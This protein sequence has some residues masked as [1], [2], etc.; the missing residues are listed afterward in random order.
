MKKKFIYLLFLTILILSQIQ[1]TAENKDSTSNNNSGFLW[2]LFG[3][4][5]SIG[6]N[7]LI[8][9]NKDYDE[10]VRSLNFSSGK[11]K[12]DLAFN[13][14]GIFY[15]YNIS[16]GVCIDFYFSSKFTDENNYTQSISNNNFSLT[17]GYLF[18]LK[19][20]FFLNPS[21]GYG[22]SELDF[23]LKRTSEDNLDIHDMFSNN[24]KVAA[25]EGRGEGYSIGC[26]I[27]YD[28]SQEFSSVL[29]KNQLES[30]SISIDI[31]YNNSFSSSWE[32]AETQIDGMPK[33]LI[34]GYSIALSIHQRI[35]TYD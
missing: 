28:F 34:R 24:T 35:L 25:I 26:S 29:G 2:D 9:D 33:Y 1:L 21:I 20:G 17:F 11:Y 12:N 3:F 31:L 22:F 6:L 19:S 30:F 27:G 16:F 7:F 18:F 32:I 15:Y 14:K 10:L 8:N 23:E 5:P 13:F 4:D